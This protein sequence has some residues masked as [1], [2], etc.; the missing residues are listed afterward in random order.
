MIERAGSRHSSSLLGLRAPGQL[1]AVCPFRK[2]RNWDV[3]NSSS[4]RV[5]RQS[6]DGMP[7]GAVYIGRQSKWGNPFKI[8]RD[9]TRS[10]VVAKYRAWIADQ[11][12]LL[13]ALPELRGRD[14]VC[15]CAPQACHGDVLLRLANE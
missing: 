1:G 11:P 9:G 5:L 2:L 6:R 15:H 13:A 8:G 14:L 10:E 4:P 7:A 12:A 3:V